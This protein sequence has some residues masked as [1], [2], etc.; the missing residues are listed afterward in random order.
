MLYRRTKWHRAGYGTP[1]AGKGREILLVA[2]KSDE[3]YRYA[4]AGLVTSLVAGKS[5]ET[6]RDADE[7]HVTSLVAG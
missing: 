5:H 2:G 4:D 1:R 7:N 6:H 3:T